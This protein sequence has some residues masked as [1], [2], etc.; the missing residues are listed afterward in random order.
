M[1]ITNN[2][3]KSIRKN[4]SGFYLALALCIVAVGAAAFI[5]YTSFSDKNNK[6]TETKVSAS[7]TALSETSENIVAV[8]KNLSDVP[9]EDTTKQ[10]KINSGSDSKVNSADAKETNAQAA[11]KVFPCGSDISKNFSGEN[12][13]YSVTLNDWRIHNGTDYIASKGD[14]VVSI[15]D[16]TVK[17]IRDDDLL[18][19]IITIAHSDGFEA[20]YCGLGEEVFVANDD[21]VE[22]GQKIATIATVP[23]ECLEE[24][25]LHL[26]IKVNDKYV[27]P[28]EF[29]KDAVKQ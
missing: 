12:P 18:G 16:G 23:C 4:Q 9:K 22:A 29:L 28:A 13:V 15:S 20:S 2:G 14:T 27:D 10:P 17:E 25:H 8:E 7:S 26:E 11:K 19:K 6:N 3:E 5:T 1:T 21:K 24:S